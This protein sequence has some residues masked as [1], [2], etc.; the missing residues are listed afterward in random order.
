MMKNAAIAWRRHGSPIL[1]IV[2]RADGNAS[3]VDAPEPH[4]QVS[5]PTGHVPWKETLMRNGRSKPVRA[6]DDRRLAVGA[7]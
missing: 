5:G 1:G 4:G 3:P 7:C 6:G 2:Q